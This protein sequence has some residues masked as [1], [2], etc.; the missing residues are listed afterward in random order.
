MAIFET[1]YINLFNPLPSVT[2]EELYKRANIRL[3]KRRMAKREVFDLELRWGGGE[4]LETHTLRPGQYI[5]L[6]ASRAIEVIQ[7]FR[8]SGDICANNPGLAHYRDGEDGKAAILTALHIAQ[9]H[10]HT[11]GAVQL[12]KL[13][14]QLGHRDEEVEQRYRNSTYASFFLAMAKEK[15][16]EDA[17]LEIETQPDERKAG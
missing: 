7:D 16:I 15:L 6:P 4:D 1:S 13:R 9:T 10:Y 11:I 17:L 2:Y 8:P 3:V 12:D 14:G 5:Q